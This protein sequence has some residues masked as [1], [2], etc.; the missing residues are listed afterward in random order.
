ML[1]TDHI[2]SYMLETHQAWRCTTDGMF[3]KETAT[4][5]SHPTSPSVFKGINAENGSL[6]MVI[7]KRN[8]SVAEIV[9]IHVKQLIQYFI[10][11]FDVSM[12]SSLKSRFALASV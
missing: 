11:H 3:W 7:K 2:R 5:K 9:K 1:V 8:I 4:C 6:K 10:F 12:H